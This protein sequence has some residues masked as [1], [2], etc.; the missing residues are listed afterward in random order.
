MIKTKY[1]L[2]VI[3]NFFFSLVILGLLAFIFLTSNEDV[4][5]VDNVKIFNGFAMT[6]ELKAVGEKE[7]KDRKLVIDSITS[8]MHSAGITAEE[9]NFL[10]QKLI[11]NKEALEQFNQSYSQEQTAKIWTR[12]HSYMDQYSNEHN[13]KVIL[14]SEYGRTVLFGSK[15]TDV[16]DEVLNYLNKKYE[17]N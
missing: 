11:Q 4:V 7:F 1:N 9:K 3:F 14:G 10:M 5:F 15:G 17:G 12:I 6:K 13:Y 2:L 8:N 16:T